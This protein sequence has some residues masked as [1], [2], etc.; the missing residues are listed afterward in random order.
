MTATAKASGPLTAESLLTASADGRLPSVRLF[1]PLLQRVVHLGELEG[2]LN[3]DLNAA[4]T[5]GEPVFIDGANLNNASLGLL[6]PGITL[7][8]IN[9]TIE[10]INIENANS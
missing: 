4:G 1:R 7:S 9:T 5:L 6:G 8:E 10:N 3:I 2:E